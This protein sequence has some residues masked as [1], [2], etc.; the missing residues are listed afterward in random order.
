[1]AAFPGKGMFFLIVPFLWMRVR[2]FS[3]GRKNNV[4]FWWKLTRF[5]DIFAGRRIV[6]MSVAGKRKP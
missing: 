5:I 4:L 1:M 6:F 2:Y 3:L